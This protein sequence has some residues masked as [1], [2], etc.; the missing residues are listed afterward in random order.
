ML[1]QS[2]WNSGV[3]V[4][5]EQSVDNKEEKRERK[6]TYRNTDAN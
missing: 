5:I 1:V 4:L 2:E 3:N 6:R